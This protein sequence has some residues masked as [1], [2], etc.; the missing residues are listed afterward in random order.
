MRQGAQRH[1]DRVDE[2]LLVAA[3]RLDVHQGRRQRSDIGEQVKSHATRG[4]ARTPNSRPS[5]PAGGAG[6][7]TRPP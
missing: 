1:I 6:N 4:Y 7:I 5:R 2:R 3:H